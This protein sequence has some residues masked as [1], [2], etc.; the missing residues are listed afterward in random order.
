M[1]T[2]D[3]KKRLESLYWL[4]IIKAQEEFSGELATYTQRAQQA[5]IDEI[6]RIED[7]KTVLILVLRYAHRWPFKDIA[8]RIHYS[9]RQTQRLHDQALEAYAERLDKGS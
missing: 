7:P 3:A 4:G 5:I 2:E 8:R 6:S 9:V 1:T